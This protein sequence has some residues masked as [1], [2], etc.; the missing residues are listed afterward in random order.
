MTYVHYVGKFVIVW[1]SWVQEAA[2]T[3]S[4][5]LSSDRWRPRRH[6][7]RLGWRRLLGSTA[8]TARPATGSAGCS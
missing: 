1:C 7:R 8:S 3:I 2:H 6:R 4:T 5:G